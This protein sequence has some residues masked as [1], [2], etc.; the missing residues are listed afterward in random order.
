MA[1]LFC[2]GFVMCR[3]QFNRGFDIYFIVL[4]LIIF[5][6]VMT[7]VCDIKYMI[8][9]YIKVKVIS[10]NPPP[11]TEMLMSPAFQISDNAIIVSKRRN[12]TQDP[13]AIEPMGRTQRGA[14]QALRNISTSRMVR[15]ARTPPG[16]CAMI[17][18]IAFVV[19]GLMQS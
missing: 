4:S 1:V 15:I 10:F 2:A 3:L 5:F 18:C 8:N 6:S 9:P 7:A 12:R 16:C 14:F 19:K 11:N 13:N 17:C